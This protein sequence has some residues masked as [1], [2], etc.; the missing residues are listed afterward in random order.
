MMS[1][2]AADENQGVLAS[3]L[4]AMTDHPDTE[5]RQRISGRVA[6]WIRTLRPRLSEED[7]EGAIVR[8][9]GTAIEPFSLAGD[10]L[11]LATIAVRA[12][13][14]RKGA[15][16]RFRVVGAQTLGTHGG[17]V[18]TDNLRGY[19]V[20]RF[21]LAAR[22]RTPWHY[23]FIAPAWRRADAAGWS[24]IPGL[25]GE[26]RMR[27]VCTLDDRGWTV[28]LP[29]MAGCEQADAGTP[30]SKPWLTG[31]VLGSKTTIH[32]L[33]V[34]VVVE[35]ASVRLEASTPEVLLRIGTLARRRPWVV[36]ERSDGR[37]PSTTAEEKIYLRLL[38]LEQER[39]VLPTAVAVVSSAAGW[40]SFGRELAPSLPFADQVAVARHYPVPGG[41][42]TGEFL[43]AIA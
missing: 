34:R 21:A 14:S 22:R 18:L 15:Q 25:G 12:A 7:V 38:P 26:R 16:K 42:V 17:L 30:R 35:K 6:E 27:A 9:P 13:F 37:S 24:G 23:W 29:P 1:K 31:R 5:L 33:G 43:E 36:L 32:S 2:P 10:D 39:I 28:V 40:L 11:R 3:M 41:W 8:Q 19:Y 4:A 20:E